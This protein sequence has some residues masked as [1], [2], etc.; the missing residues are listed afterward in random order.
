MIIK[1][2]KCTKAAR[3]TWTFVKNV[4]AGSLTVSDRGS[5]GRFTLKGLYRCECGA[6]KHGV[7]DH[8]AKN[9]DLRGLVGTIVSMDEA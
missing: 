8:N 4:K 7:P 6:T 2:P 9:A 1:T 3:H 5:H